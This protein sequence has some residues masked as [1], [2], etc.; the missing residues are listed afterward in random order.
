MQ[1]Q[2]RSSAS[3]GSVSSVTTNNDEVLTE[4]LDSSSA[5][6]NA[7]FENRQEAIVGHICTA[8][9]NQMIVNQKMAELYVEI[10]KLGFEKQ[11][12]PGVVI[13][14]NHI[15]LKTQNSKLKTTFTRC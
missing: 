11:I 1:R 8:A 9:E 13:G 7:A 5:S 14:S 3:K 10:F 12:S 15:T 6:S 4:P 2:L